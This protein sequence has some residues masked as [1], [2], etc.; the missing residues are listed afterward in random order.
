MLVAA[1]FAVENDDPYDERM[2]GGAKRVVAGTGHGAAAGDEVG[3]RSDHAPAVTRAAAALQL[4]AASPVVLGLSEIARSLGIPKSSASYICEA[5]VG[6]DLARREDNGY[7]LGHRLV[8]LASAYLAGADPVRTF[9]AVCREYLPT[10]AETVQLSTLHRGLEVSYLARCEGAATVLLAT[11]VGSRLGATTTATGKSML[12]QLP[13]SETAARLRAARPLPRLTVRSIGSENELRAELDVIRGRGYALDDEETLEGM[14]CIGRAVPTDDTSGQ[15]Y[16]I[17]LTMLKSWA[18]P[19]RIE[20]CRADLDRVAHEV[21]V[22]AG[23]VRGPWPLDGAAGRAGAPAPTS[24]PATR[25]TIE[26]S[27]PLR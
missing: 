1:V 18:T 6:A 9:H 11:S 24:P 5:L 17:S 7:Q 26:T 16:G 27:S 23:L 13:W 25:R 8:G 3:S 10:I 14:F 22:R 2:P 21:S 15:L 12:A 4:F 19:E 20:R